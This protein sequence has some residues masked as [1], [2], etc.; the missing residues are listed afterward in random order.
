MSIDSIFNNFE[1]L[2]DQVRHETEKSRFVLAA[3]T[4]LG[5]VGFFLYLSVISEGLM[6]LIALTYGVLVLAIIW[7]LGRL[8]RSALLLDAVRISKN[9]FSTAYKLIQEAQ[10]AVH[11]KKKIDAYVWSGSQLSILVLHHLDRKILLLSPKV[12]E[13]NPTDDILR[14]SIMFHIA[15]LKTRSEYFSLL[16]SII[17]GVERIWIVNFLLYPFE[18]ATV[19]TADRVAMIYSGKSD[20]AQ[21]ALAK[22]MLGSEVSKQVNVA[23]VSLQGKE[24]KGFFAW[25]AK[26]YSSTPGYA[27]RFV[28]L[29]RFSEISVRLMMERHSP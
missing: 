26:S 9:N 15:R 4:I 5:L 24:A 11:Y 25:L 6:T 29:D 14:F 19:F 21:K 28:E 22:E 13:G 17:S 1:E 2:L 23:E 27:H 8:V 18:R 12:V 7:L 20:I 3:A 16:T 10:S